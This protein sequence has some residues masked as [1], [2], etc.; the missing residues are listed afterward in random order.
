MDKRTKVKWLGPVLLIALAALHGCSGSSSGGDSGDSGDAGLYQGKVY[1]VGSLQGEVGEA[2]RDSLANAVSYD[3]QAK[4]API[5][6]AGSEVRRLDSWTAA[7]IAGAYKE[8][9]P[10]AVVQATEEEVNA[11]LAMLGLEQN[12]KLPTGLPEGKAYADLFAADIEANGDSHVWALYPPG[13]SCAE[14]CGGGPAP[15]PQDQAGGDQPGLQVMELFLE[16]LKEDGKRAEKLQAADAAAGQAIAQAADDKNLP[17]IARKEVY[18]NAF[19]TNCSANIANAREKG[20]DRKVGQEGVY[21][22]RHTYY[23]AHSFNTTDGMDSDWFYVQ[24]KASLNLSNCFLFASWCK[25]YE[26]VPDLGYKGQEWS[27]D[28]CGDYA[29][30]YELDSWIEGQEYYLNPNLVLVEDSPSTASYVKKVT[31]G[32]TMNFGGKVGFSKAGLPTPEISAGVTIHDSQEFEVPDTWVVNDSRNRHNNARWHYAFADTGSSFFPNG[33][34]GYWALNRPPEVTRSNFSLTNQWVWKVGP[35]L[36]NDPRAQQ[37][38]VRFRAQKKRTYAGKPIVQ[39]AVHVMDAPDD[40]VFTVPLIYPPQLGTTPTQL[41]FGVAGGN[42]DVDLAA[43]RN[44][45]ASCDQPWCTVFPASG[46]RDDVPW[47]HVMVDRNDTGGP[48]QAIVTVRM[49]DGKGEAKITVFQSRI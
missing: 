41:S 19:R 23:A 10:I 14:G 13:E 15:A 11:L 3:G 17:K 18:D 44:W 28:C 24:Q 43:S 29:R 8:N 16:W 5:F 7:G 38:K 4:D 9:L 20:R 42:Q 22:I 37:F 26:D 48:R 21:Q 47:L 45:I 30:F 34:P 32:I 27:I 39:G 49:V 25:L 35:A 6:I 40:W 2:L 12:Y 1:M 33:W 31:S 36:R 46:T